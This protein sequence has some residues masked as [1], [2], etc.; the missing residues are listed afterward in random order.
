MALSNLSTY[1]G[2]TS[3]M[4]K[5]SSVKILRME[6]A[7]EPSRIPK[8]L[9]TLNSREDLQHFAMGCDADIGGL[10]SCHLDLD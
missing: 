9:F 3:R 8:T 4:L 7:D 2:R 6:G 5:E 1:F 10:S